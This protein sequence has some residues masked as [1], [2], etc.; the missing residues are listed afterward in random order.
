MQFGINKCASLVVG[1]ISKFLNNSNPTFN[2]L[3]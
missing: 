3:R 1:E 2:I